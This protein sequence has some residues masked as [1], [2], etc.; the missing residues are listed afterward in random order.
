MVMSHSVRVSAERVF[1]FSKYQ[2]V[3]SLHDL[4]VV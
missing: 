2:G 4:G 1:G 3:V